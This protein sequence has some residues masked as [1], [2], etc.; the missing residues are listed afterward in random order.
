[1]RQL[2]SDLIIF[3]MVMGSFRFERDVSD[4]KIKYSSTSRVNARSR[5]HLHLRDVHSALAE[6]SVGNADLNS[7]E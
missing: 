6:Y 7:T 3:K 4:A 1:M 5:L 2:G